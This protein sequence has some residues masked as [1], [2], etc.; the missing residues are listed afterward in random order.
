MTTR[1]GKSTRDPPHPNHAEKA[2][3]PQAEEEESTEPDDFEEPKEEN[4]R[5]TFDISFLPFASRK[6][7][8][9][10]DEQFARFVEMIQKIH[11]NVPLL[12]VMLVQTYARYIKDIINNKRPLPTM[13]VVKLTE[14]CSATILNQPP[15]KKED[16]GCPM[17][18]CSIGTQ[19]FGNALCDL[20]ASVSVMPKVVFD[21]LNFT[22][23]TPTP[24]HL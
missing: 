13:E 19:H 6:Q 5:E 21:K 1:G 15:K 24:M 12:D 7:K 2:A 20:G 9:T 17:I 10:V 8:I 22:Q 3:T 23:L 11:V 14:E 16:P 4:P 18:N